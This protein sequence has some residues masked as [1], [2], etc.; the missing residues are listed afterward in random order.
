MFSSRARALRVFLVMVAL[1]LVSSCSRSSPENSANRSVS[2]ADR[3]EVVEDAHGALAFDEVASPLGALAFRP[4]PGPLNLGLTQS[5]FWFRLKIDAEKLG[6]ENERS[7]FSI[8]AYL[9]EVEVY[10]T[11]DPDAPGTWEK[12]EPVPPP[13]EGFASVA[14]DLTR[15]H[16]GAIWL[17]VRAHSLDSFYFSPRLMSVRT[18]VHKSNAVKLGDG[19]YYGVMIGAIVYN[20]FLA[21]WMRDRSYLYYILFEGFFAATMACMDR[22]MAVVLPSAVPAMRLGLTERLMG[23]TGIAAVLFARDFLD[24]RK[25]PRITL[26][27]VATVLGGFLLIFFPLSVGRQYFYGYGNLF[28]ITSTLFVAFLAIF[29]WRR[30]NENAFWF[31]LA[32]GTLLFANAIGS[33]RN[34]GLTTPWFSIIEVIKIGSGA[35]ALL[36]AA[37]LARRMSAIKRAEGNARAALAEA[38]LGLAQVLER[39][40]AALHTLIS[41]VAHEIGNPLN[42]ATGGARDVIKRLDRA[43]ALAAMSADDGGASPVEPLQDVLAAARR[44]AT[45]AA[46]GTERIGAIVKNLRAYVG[47]GAQPMES[48]DL[49]ENIRSTVALLEPHFQSRQIDVVLDLVIQSPVQ[50]SPGEMSQVIMNLAL[51]A[52]QAMPAGGKLVIRSEEGSDALRIVVTDTGA[53]VPAEL[54]HVI[55][56]P[57]FTTRAPNEGTGLGLAVSREIVRRHGGTLELLAACV[58]ETGAQFAITLPRVPQR[59]T[60]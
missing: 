12:L 1:F 7:I 8:G 25:L 60:V 11:N 37:A 28:V 13:Q 22:T 44:S 9:D 3:I 52:C 36:L 39:Q 26:A 40:V 2:L 24:L 14:Y 54:R 16:A 21:F 32:W 50:C 31:V 46:R 30:G 20:L 58:H 19:I 35:E 53:G 47:T 48:T 49:D 43:E 27:S 17:L 10:A 59:E 38:R 5:V 23:A 4:L 51:N 29:S 18:Y 55:F 6:A 57:F 33:L 15:S 34:L 42:F 41:G 56:D 45:L